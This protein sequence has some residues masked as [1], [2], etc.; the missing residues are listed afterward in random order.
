M[1][2]SLTV[3][4]LLLVTTTLVQAQTITVTGQLRERSE[5]SDKIFLENAHMD[6]F[7]LL[8]ARL[9]AKAAITDRVSVVVEV[10]DARYF[11]G[12]ASTQNM[13]ASAFDLRQ[14]YL[15]VTG[16]ADGY[17]SFKLGRQV[18]AYAN[19][20]LLGGIDWSNFGQSF[21]A[22]VL[23]LHLGDV[24]VDAIGAAIARNPINI[25]YARDVFLTGLWGTWT[26]EGS[27]NSV[28]AFWL[29]DTPAAS[30]VRQNRHT[31]GVVAGGHMGMLDYEIEG[32][33]QFGD[34]I[35][36]ANEEKHHISAN[37]IGARVGYRFPDAL[38]LRIGAGVD[39]LSGNDP[40][41]TDTYGVFNTLYGTNH[42]FYGFMDYFTNIPTHTGNLGLMDI[43]GQVSI[44]PV[45]DV[46]FAVDVHLFSTVTDPVKALPTRDP[47]WSSSIGTEI[48][49]TAKWK[50]AEVVG[51]T[52]GFSMF[53]A[54]AD[55]P[56]LRAIGT[57]TES[58]T[59]G[60]LMTTVNF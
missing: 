7:H 53:S 56:V 8:R 2:R 45:K 3:G 6:A 17:V 42:K 44:V 23:R 57:T 58:T 41:K 39:R 4:I 24:R 16:C 13:G 34:H 60:Y 35:M 32:A 40:E 55:R 37:M 26:P 54:N 18:L 14:G 20:R 31:A 28:N 27:R 15:E 38:G 30:L 9:G 22:G 19:E 51:M 11:G 43:I 5:F 1:L 47:A 29:F 10:Q 12:S 33:M 21:D 48:D 36:A 52:A 59:W 46:V 50:L 25:D 49:V